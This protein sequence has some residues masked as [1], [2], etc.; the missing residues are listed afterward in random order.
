M[1]CLAENNLQRHLSPE[2][3]TQNN[4]SSY[5]NADHLQQLGPYDVI[6]GRHKAAFDNIGNR[7]FRITVAL[8]LARYKA[9]P[10]REDKSIIIHSVVALVRSCGGR[11]LQ[12]QKEAWVELDDK[13]AH[14][15]VGHAL[16]DMAS[17]S[18]K[19]SKNKSTEQSGMSPSATLKAFAARWKFPMYMDMAIQSEYLQRNAPMEKR[20]VAEEPHDC[21]ETEEAEDYE[22]DAF[23][24]TE[25]P[26]CVDYDEQLQASNDSNL[27]QEQQPIYQLSQEPQQDT[28]E[29]LLVSEF[30]DFSDA[31]EFLLQNIDERELSIDDKMI[32]WM[33]N[34]S[35][36]LFAG[37]ESV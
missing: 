5:E 13:M 23:S 32:S 7:R 19:N 34:E 18:N 33:V 30:E 15:K 35:T 6:C 20:N 29:A 37:L 24:L 17:K 2:Q 27:S 10:I 26:I 11:F 25:D 22:Y 31:Q 36:S 4:P 9:A 12:R 28:D 16:R 1:L 8:S 3:T 21:Q 14:E